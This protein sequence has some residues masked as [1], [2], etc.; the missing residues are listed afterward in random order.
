[1]TFYDVMPKTSCGERWPSMTSIYDVVPPLRGHRRHDVIDAIRPV[2][3][4]ARR[5]PMTSPMTSLP[6]K[7]IP[8]A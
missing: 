4:Q 6:N 7:R 1:M 5:S 3:N 2:D 8:A